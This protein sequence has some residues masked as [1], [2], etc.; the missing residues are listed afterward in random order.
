M[1]VVRLSQCAPV[2]RFFTVYEIIMV[3]TVVRSFIVSVTVIA[4]FHPSL[5]QINSLFAYTL[6]R[7]QDVNANH[8]VVLG[9]QRSLRHTDV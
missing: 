6:K 2:W 4:I 3:R 9:A 7:E 1:Y 8:F 5:N